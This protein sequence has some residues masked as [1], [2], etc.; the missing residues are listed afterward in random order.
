MPDYKKKSVKKV[1]LNNVSAPKKQKF[2]AKKATKSIA[3]KTKKPVSHE[4]A[5]PVPKKKKASSGI[6]MPK[7][8]KP[9]INKP[10]ENKN[11]KNTLKLIN[12]NIIKGKKGTKSLKGYK[13]YIFVLILIIA[14]VTASLLT[15]TGLIEYTKTVIMASGSAKLPKD[16]TG[17]KIVHTESVD[18]RVN[19]LTD[20]TY[21]LYNTAGKKIASDT[22]GFSN[23]VMR[24]SDT[25]TLVFDQKGVGYK[26]Y[27]V[28]GVVSEGE[29]K[30]DIICGEMGRNGSYAIVTK[31]A[32]FAAKLEVFTKHN[33]KVFSWSSSKELI[34]GVALSNNGK[35]IAVSVFYSNAGQ[36]VNK[37]YIF[38]YKN[39]LPVN[40]IE[41]PSP[42]FYIKTINGSKFAVVTSDEVDLV[43]F[44]NGGKSV[45]NAK[46][47]ILKFRK[48][49]GSE[50][51]V[52]CENSDNN[53]ETRLVLFNGKGEVKRDL[54]YNGNITDF[55]Y[56]SGKFYCLDNNRILKLD[57]TGKPTAS[58]ECSYSIRK[59][60][61]SDK[62]KITTISDEKLETVKLGD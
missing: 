1:K 18:N 32:D 3:K 51:C 47:K 55:I 7:I 45:F 22:H 59:F 49:S 58:V 48:Y 44:S 16:I 19:M 21:L 5:A 39:A 10:S 41:M 13:K 33:K 35:K 40:T 42:I 29:T 57:D 8:K 36:E 24:T 34:T 9:N 15:P 50:Y 27:N 26:I 61:A 14:V 37:V 4:N 30:N 62:N 20:S 11:K 31:P 54:I 53:L 60:Y 28:S 23:P 46:G 52:A 6:S 56:Y 17:N 12:F 25:R 38:N 43:D 2:P